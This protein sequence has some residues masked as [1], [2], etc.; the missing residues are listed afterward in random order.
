MIIGLIGNKRVGKDTVADFLCSTYNFKKYAFADGVKETC[1]VL[2]DFTDEQMNNDKKEDI[3]IQWNISPRKAMQFIGTEIMQYKIQ[4]L[5]PDIKKLFWVN[6]LRNKIIKENNIKDI[7]DLHNN[8]VITD[9]RFLHEINE[10]KNIMF[11]HIL[12]NKTYEGEDSHI[13]E[14]EL[15][16]IDI[17]CLDLKKCHIIYN[18]GSLDD[19]YSKMEDIKGDIQGDILSPSTPSG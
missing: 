12:R 6:R 5:I 9:F 15:T 13:S 2:F 11:I 16:S 3:D 10:F 4:E 1:K 7:G 17:M 14:N 8:I 19:L 18:N